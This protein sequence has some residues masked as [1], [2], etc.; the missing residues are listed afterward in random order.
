[1]QVAQGDVADVL[2]EQA[3]GQGFGVADDQAALGVFRD[4]AAGHVRMADSDQRLAGLASFQRGFDQA[5]VHLADTAQVVIAQLCAGHFGRPQEGQGQ[6]PGRDLAAGVGQWNQQA[7]AVEDAVIEPLHPA[8]GMGAQAPHQRRWQFDARAGVVVAGDHHDVQ[9]GLLFV[10]LDDEV[11]EPLLGFDRRI[12]GVEDV[13]GNQQGIG[14]AQLELAEQPIEKTGVFEIAFLAV[15]GLTQVPV[16]GVKQTHEGF[17]NVPAWR[18]GCH[19]WR[20]FGVQ[21]RQAAVLALRRLNL[22]GGRDGANG[23]P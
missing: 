1:M 5:L 9:L 23:P 22:L 19:A 20:L 13:A 2:A 12:D 4:R 6:A 16:G 7:I 10:G 15:Q 18:S 3:G 17:R 21:R 14:L 11:V 8:Q